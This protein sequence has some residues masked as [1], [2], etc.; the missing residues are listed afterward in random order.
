[1][2]SKQHHS[3]DECHTSF[4]NMVQFGARPSDLVE[5]G[6][7]KPQKAKKNRGFK[8]S[9]ITHNSVSGCSNLFKFGVDIEHS[10]YHTR[11]R[12]MIK[13]Q[14]HSMSSRVQNSLN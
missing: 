6:V 7:E 13:G 8:R 9:K 14:G 11:S 4:P 2:K 5:V 10:I 3:V 12:S 1:V